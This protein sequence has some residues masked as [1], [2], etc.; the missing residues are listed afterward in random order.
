MSSDGFNSN[1][2]NFCWFWTI[3]SHVVQEHPGMNEFCSNAHFPFWISIVFQLEKWVIGLNLPASSTFR[4]Y[5][6]TNET[7]PLIVQDRSLQK[8][9]FVHCIMRICSVQFCWRLHAIMKPCSSWTF[10][11]TTPNYKYEKFMRAQLPGCDKISFKTLVFH[12][13]LLN[14]LMKIMTQK[15]SKDITDPIGGQKKVMFSEHNGCHW[16]PTWICQSE[17]ISSWIEQAL[18]FLPFLYNWHVCAQLK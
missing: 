13:T 7:V 5:P 2:K 9:K 14:P 6:I 16:C 12:K 15:I 11:T 17:F 8:W 18:T 3:D 10:T 1:L 4:C